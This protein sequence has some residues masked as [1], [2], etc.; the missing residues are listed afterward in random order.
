[1]NSNTNDT[2]K[3]TYNGKEVIVMNDTTV[4]TFLGLLYPL[5]KA[6]NNGEFIVD[7]GNLLFIKP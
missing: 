2:M 3:P 4:E 1:M 6:K 5:V 7:N